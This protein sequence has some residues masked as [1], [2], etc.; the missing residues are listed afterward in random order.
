MCDFRREMLCVLSFLRERSHNRKGR[1]VKQVLEETIGKIRAAE[2]QADAA[3]AE[4]RAEAA[5]TLDEAKQEA[6]A[7]A[8][9]EET[10]ARTRAEEAMAAARAEGD[11]VR[12]RAEAEIASEVRA[13]RESA[14]AKEAAIVEQVLAQLI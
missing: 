11:E 7:L 5:R 1:L 6:A 8:A 13:L 3:I 4:A 2:A 12:S 14:A 10:A 9:S